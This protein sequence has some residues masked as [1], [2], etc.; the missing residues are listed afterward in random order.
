MEEQKMSSLTVFKNQ[1]FG[2][3]RTILIDDEPYFVGKDVAEILGYERATKAI[4]DHVDGD[5]IHEVPIQDSIGRM[6]STPI[7]NE[8]GLY[9]LILSS[10]LPTAKR[11]KKWVT[12]EVLPQIRKTGKYSYTPKSYAEA[13]RLYADEVEQ[14]ELMQKQR[15]EAIR[16][17]AWISGKKTATTMNTA[18]QKSKE[19]EK[20]KIELDR[21]K[22]FSSIKA[23]EIR[24][25]SKFDWKPLR[26]YC[27]SHE[28]EM[29]KIFDA[30]YGSVRTYPAEAW[31]K[32]YGVD[33]NEL[34]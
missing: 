32:I 25:K 5:D 21:S 18:S 28:L 17:K 30:N 6:Q 10:K 27:T 24:L 15:D 11:F 31:Q 23:A 4:R 3:V 33:L 9:S 22:K 29:P 34:F 19:V 20:L 2:E 16:T 8:S 13:L 1:D 12:S 26:N 14:K 7:V